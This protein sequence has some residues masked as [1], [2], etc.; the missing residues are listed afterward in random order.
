MKLP[1]LSTLRF[2]DIAAKA[3]SFVKAA[4]ELNVTHSAI[5]RQIRLLEEHLGVELFERRNRAVFLTPEGQ[6]LLQTTRGM[7]EQL[8]AAVEQIKT[9]STPDVVSL[10]CEPTIAMKWLIPRLTDFYQRYP[11]ITVHLVAAGGAIDFAKTHVDL[12]LRRND[13]SW[14]GQIHAMK[15]CSEQMGAVSLRSGGSMMLP[16]LVSVSRPDAWKTWQQKSGVDLTGC[17]YV[18]YEHFYLC[19][20]AALAGQGTALASF[21]MVID[22]IQSGQLQSS[23][24]F[25]PDGS[26]YYLLSPKPLDSHHA[27]AI[28]ANWLIEQINISIDYINNR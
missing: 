17:K 9:N 6:L 10:S 24:G 18:T 25:I 16:L 21:L 4:Q 14:G 28:F 15:V 11:H 13:F 20:Q 2:F 23:D 3:G 22:E 5:S 1:P 27:A 7:F 19:I 12:A 26:A 8:S